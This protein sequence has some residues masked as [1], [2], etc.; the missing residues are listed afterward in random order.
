[1]V[2]VNPHC[3]PSQVAVPCDGVGQAVQEVPQLATLA[4]AEQVPPQ[5]WLPPG[6]SPAHDIACGTHAVAHSFVPPEQVEPQEVPSQVAA[7]PVGTKHG[8]HPWPQCVGSMLDTHCPLHR[9]APDPQPVSALPASAVVM[10]SRFAS[11]GAGALS[12][13]GA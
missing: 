3:V 8:L 2:Q 4:F 12:T 1:V 7:P 9:C 6:Q 13:A 5:S 10:V 11:G